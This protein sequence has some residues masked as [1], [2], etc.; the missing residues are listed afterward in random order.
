MS[1]EIE[2]LATDSAARRASGRTSPLLIA[3]AV[4]A[5][6]LAL[7]AHWRFNR[8]DD[9]VDA[10]RMQLDEV[11][12]AQTRLSGQ[13]GTLAAN[14]DSSSAAWRS[15][16]AGLRELPAQIGELGRGVEELRARTEAPQRAWVRAEALYLLE[17]AQRR[18]ELERDLVTAIAAMETADARLAAAGDPAVADVR[19]EL[20]RE[21]AALRAV[22][23][24]DLPAVLARVT[25]L[26]N[27]VATLPVQGMPAIE[28][29]RAPAPPA[30][31]SDFARFRERVTRALGDLFSLRRVDPSTAT[32][33]TQEQDSLRR[34][35]LELLLV[36]ARIAAMQQD[37]D[38]YR[39]SLQA[40]DAR[41]QQYFDL[42]RPEVEHARD[43]ITA[44]ASIDIDPPRPQIGEAMRLL[45]RII[46]SGAAPQ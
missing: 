10:V 26:E 30:P 1:A 6:A 40:A 16:I 36:G 44:L 29:K 12:A 23:V 33:V 46:Q 9:R 3:L 14:M 42:R 5:L 21:I 2:S 37:G 28:A 19:R 32:L 17:L 4:S 22:P 18:L 31:Q 7:H 20:A 39:R 41:L 11:R 27:G 25:A 35:H 43:E 24:A 34:Q 13:L 8:F 15:E 45:Q 38:T